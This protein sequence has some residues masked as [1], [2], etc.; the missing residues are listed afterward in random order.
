MASSALWAQ[1]PRNVPLQLSMTG[2]RLTYPAERA[3]WFFQVPSQRHHPFSF[4]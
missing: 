1:K 2:F 3:S 4:S